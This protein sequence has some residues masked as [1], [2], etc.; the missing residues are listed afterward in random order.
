M[1]LVQYQIFKFT[2]L[3]K[4]EQNGMKLRKKK[5]KNYGKLTVKHVNRHR[6]FCKIA[7]CTCIV[8]GIVPIRIRYI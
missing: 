8:A 1:G 5:M 2:K 3:A 6:D 7:N 4:N